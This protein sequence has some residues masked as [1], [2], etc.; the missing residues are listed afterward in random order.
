MD[1]KFTDEQVLLAESLKECLLRY[2][3]EIE[4]SWHAPYELP[5]NAWQAL[6]D[7]GFLAIGFPEEFGGTPADVTTQQLVNYIIAKYG[8]PLAGLYSHGLTMMHALRDFATDEQRQELIPKYLNGGTPTCL[9]LTEPATGSDL[10]ALSTTYVWDGDDII[11]NGHKHYNTMAS[12]V[13][14]VLLLIKDARYESPFG[15]VTTVI[16]P[17]DAPGVTITDMDKFGGP[18]PLHICEI[19]L[20]D[21]RLPKSAI[22]GVEHEGLEQTQKN[23]LMERIGSAPS[24]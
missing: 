9:A 24:Q 5:W 23:F 2:Q 8:G 7:N 18:S 15:A 1:V 20:K 4:A 10:A 11:I 13:D 6:A 14:N 21:V 22:L 17:T 19:F 16:L 3:D 12:Q